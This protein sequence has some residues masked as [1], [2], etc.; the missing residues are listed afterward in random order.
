LK[1]GKDAD[2]K[3]FDKSIS[4]WEWQWVNSH[5]NYPLQASG[6]SVTQA[7]IIYKKYRKIIGAAYE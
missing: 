1:Q 7:S 4:Q 5:K 3:G 2:L 6:N